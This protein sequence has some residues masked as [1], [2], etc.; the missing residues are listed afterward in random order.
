MTG[1]ILITGAD[2]GIGLATA[3]LALEQGWE[4]VAAD[5]RDGDGLAALREDGADT[6]TVDLSSLTELTAL[7]SRVGRVNA[8]I[9]SAGIIRITPF[10][11]IS[12]DDWHAVMSI[13][14]HA[15]FFLSRAV[16]EMMGEGDGIVN[17]ASIAAHRAIHPEQ[18]VYAASK[19]ALCSI[20]RSFAHSYGERGIRVNSVLP[21]LIETPMNEQVIKETAAARDLDADEYARSRAAGVPLIRVGTPRDVA[22][23]A[24]WLLSPASSYMTGQSIVVD[25]GLLML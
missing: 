4:V 21:G 20:T 23:A 1:R 11:A 8:L 15:P 5:L 2:S 13:N 10:D 24:L 18:T 19:A 17:I 7:T 6:Y 14:V 16:A 12:E 25:G 22:D 3:A 9:N